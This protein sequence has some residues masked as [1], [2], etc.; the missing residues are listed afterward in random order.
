[1]AEYTDMHGIRCFE[2][3]NTVNKL[4]IE[5]G[6]GLPMNEILDKITAHFGEIAPEHISIGSEH[7][8]TRCLGYDLYDGADWT[9]F[10]V[11]ERI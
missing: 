8:Q 5:N 11:I 4:Y 7:I 1:M 3:D 6:Y 10:T 9:T 2:P